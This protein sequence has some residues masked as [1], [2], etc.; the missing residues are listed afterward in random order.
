MQHIKEIDKVALIAKVTGKSYQV[1]D[2]VLGKS[3]MNTIFGK[4]LV[5][6]IISFQIVQVNGMPHN[7]KDL[8]T[9]CEIFASGGD[10]HKSASSDSRDTGTL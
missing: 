5:D 4:V 8:C 3:Q 1:E 9:L 10:N 6:A 2:F 7:I